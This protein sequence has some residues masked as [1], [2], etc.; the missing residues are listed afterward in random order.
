MLPRE[1]AFTI[2]LKRVILRTW[3]TQ[4]ITNMP[5]ITEPRVKGNLG[6]WKHSWR[7]IRQGGGLENEIEDIADHY[8]YVIPS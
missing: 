3:R 6:C 4:D 1:Q 2:R 7:M 5:Q 8:Y